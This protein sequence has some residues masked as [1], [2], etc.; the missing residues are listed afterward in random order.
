MFAPVP[1]ADASSGNP[2]RRP[3]NKSED[4]TALRPPVK[5]RKRS[6]L[7]KE[8]FDPFSSNSLNIYPSHGGPGQEAERP[9]RN[10][11]SH[12][13]HARRQDSPSLPSLTL[14]DRLGKKGDRLYRASRQDGE[15]DLVNPT[16]STCQGSLRL[17][18]EQARTHHYT[19]SKL[20][21]NPETLLQSCKQGTCL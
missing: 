21:S 18:H 10:G 9:T 3:R 12:G 1:A 20:S 16:L 5:R 7:S 14:R 6:R 11:Y 4:S 15:M 19:I 8:T 17:I 2:R 13:H